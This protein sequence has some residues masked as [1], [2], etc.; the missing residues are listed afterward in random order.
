[1]SNEPQHFAETLPHVQLVQMASA[2]WVSKVLY[3]AAKLGLAD[4]LGA[5]PKDAAELAALTRTHAPSL[6]RLMRTLASVGILAQD[7]QAKF[8]LTPL[9]AALQTGAP[10]SARASVL[11]L[12][13]PWFVESFEHILHS[14][15][16]GRPGFAEARGMPVFDYL[17]QHPAE[18]ALF[19]ETMVGFHGQEPPA[20]AA[21]YDFSAVRTLVDVGGSGGNMLAAILLRYPELRGVLFD[22]A[23]VVADAGPFLQAQGIADR[24]VTQ[25]GDFFEAVPAGGDA[26]L[27]SHILHDWSEEQ[28]L[29]IL[30]NVRQ[31]MNP[32]G[33]LLVVEMV[34]PDDDTPHPGK[35]LDMVMLT[36]AGGQERTAVEY[37]ALLSRAGFRLTRV[38]PTASAASVVEAVA[39]A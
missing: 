19:V 33:R 14:V 18:A 37:S 3:A 39:S 20:V 32:Q 6:H 21:A 34:L 25:G 38:V 23:H 35:M 30:R 7:G 31:A 11:T 2:Y 8:A 16:T 24:V 15:E 10:G 12:S 17:A 1:M 5:G 4:H 29:T 13:G 22:L 36:V 28:A 26:Y 9:G 27:L